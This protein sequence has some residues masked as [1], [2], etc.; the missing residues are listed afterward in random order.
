MRDYSDFFSK[1]L[2]GGVGKG[3]A[4]MSLNPIDLT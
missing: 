4:K 3:N 2:Y 1:L